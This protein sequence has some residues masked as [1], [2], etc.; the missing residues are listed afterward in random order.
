MNELYLCDSKQIDLKATLDGGQAFRWHQ[1]K[2]GFRGIIGHSSFYIF[3]KN[4]KIYLQ[5]DNLTNEKFQLVKNYLDLEYDLNLLTRNFKNNLFLSNLFKKYFGLRI[6]K[7]DPW[8]TVVCFIT[9]SVSN[10]SK[11][12]RN[13]NDLCIST[14]DKVN[15]GKY[16]FAFPGPEKIINFG[17][18]NLRK[19]GFGFRA[20]YIIDASK[21]VINKDIVLSDLFNFSYQ[22]SL[23]ELTEING[24]GRKV[25]DCIMTYGLQREDV[26]A[27]DR[28][29][30]RGLI[31]KL[32]YNKKYTN[33]QL[34]IIA[35]NNFGSFS[36]YI[37]QYIFYGEKT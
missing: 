23:N 10:I 2:N 15:S 6:L 30:R 8:E 3:K 37:Q 12:K 16:D 25:A 4:K 14:G 32:N 27:V 29:V 36:S 7:Q 11:I 34:S 28:W 5:S 13:V 1:H 9:S 24:V 20:P 22:K 19:L 33:D 26:F 21:K 31:N 18:E 17:E 35:R